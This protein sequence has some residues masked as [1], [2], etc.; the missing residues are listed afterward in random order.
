MTEPM[1][2]GE[3]S[4]TPASL[5]LHTAAWYGDR[6]LNLELPSTW[7]VSVFR[8]NT[9]P[10]LT[11][12][13]LWTRL[14]APV[15]ERPIRERCSASTQPLIIV[16]DLNRPTPAWRILPLIVRQFTEAGVPKRNITILVGPGTHAPPSPEAVA[17]KVG[18][19]MIRDCRVRGHDS[20]SP[21][22]KIGQT[23]FG[24]PVLVPSEVV[25][26]NFVVGVGGVYPNHTAGFGGG[27]KAALGILG[28]R[29]IAA[30]HFGHRSAGWGSESNDSTF[31]QDLGEI[32]QLIGLRTAV[33]VATDANRQIVDLACGAVDSLY[34][35]FLASAKQAFR[36]PRPDESVNVVVSNT[37]PGDLSLTFVQM[38]GL[39]PL[40]HAPAG[41]S[42]IVIGSCSEG[43]GFHG[44][45]P[46]MN[47]P[48]F[49]R[50]EMLGLRVRAN[51][52]QPRRLVTKGTVK[53]ARRVRTRVLRSPAPPSRHPTWLFCPSEEALTMLPPE[54]PGF[55]LTSSWPEIVE[56]V[57]HEQNDRAQLRTFVYA[58]APLQW[59][60]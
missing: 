30:L 20:R 1:I 46:F 7:D 44:L 56:A 22:V 37:Y 8:P 55:R 50:Y 45:F 48:R 39:V 4:S 3:S 10:A 51:R 53:V 26:S 17:K 42:R 60:A 32:A 13:E 12:D 9:G 35:P 25:T 5:E 11:D 28:F 24:T 47:A 52:K 15:D 33:L 40:A 54:I 2:I 14:D 57:G 29:S 19:D 16:D 18:A 49:H 59:L 21:V 58:V 34:P 38:K 43:L 41:A 31:R 23:S 27:A 36:A 6:A